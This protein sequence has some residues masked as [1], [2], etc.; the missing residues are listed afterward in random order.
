[1]KEQPKESREPNLQISL[2]TPLKKPIHPAL[3]V[4]SISSPALPPLHLN[5]LKSTPASNS[6][7]SSPFNKFLAAKHAISSRVSKVALPM[8]GRMTQLKEKHNQISRK[9]RAK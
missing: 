3:H 7:P 2:S 1:M 8:W 9:E 6:S 4:P 5:L